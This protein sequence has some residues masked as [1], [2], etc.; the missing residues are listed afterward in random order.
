M[1]PMHRKKAARRSPETH[2]MSSTVCEQSS[3]RHLSD[4]S[5]SADD[6]TDNN[7]AIW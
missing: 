7:D 6:T 2:E 3:R 1:Q 5:S 4:V